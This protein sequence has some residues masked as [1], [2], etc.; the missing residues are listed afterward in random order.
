MGAAMVMRDHLYREEGL[1]AKVYSDQGP[2]FIS[3]FMKEFYK[4]V[5]IEET[6]V[7][8]ITLRPTVKQNVSTGKWK[9]TCRCS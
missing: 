7:L 8:S 1:L 4:L 9:N 6:Q 5:G 2:Q 3:R